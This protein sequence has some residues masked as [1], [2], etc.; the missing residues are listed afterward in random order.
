[1]AH[2]IAARFAQLAGTDFYPAS[3][4]PKFATRELDSGWLTTVPGARGTLFYSASDADPA[5][6]A[7][8]E[9][10]E[11]LVSGAELNT[12]VAL[13]PTNDTLAIHVPVLD[14]LGSNDLT[15]CGANPQGYLFDCSSGAA[16]A[17]QE[18]PFYS[19]EAHIHGCVI[20]GSGHDIS[21]ARNNW[22]QVNDSC[23]KQ[24]RRKQ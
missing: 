10:R 2:S 21:L 22:L 20:R 5:V 24:T 6:I 17:A 19:P 8:D 16:V 1:V 18:A 7:A 23:N 12:G 11:A 9:Q 4:D 15:T 13:V 3:M 14:I